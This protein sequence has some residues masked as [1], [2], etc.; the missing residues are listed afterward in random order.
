MNKQIISN[1]SFEGERPLFGIHHV[2]L[3]RVSILP[4]ES[5]LKEC[6]DIEAVNCEFN[7]KYPFWHVDGFTVKDCLFLLRSSAALLYSRRLGMYDT[8]VD[9][10]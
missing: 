8:R 7:G 3:E 10:P 4:G 9:A 6:S 1:A 5:A 2:R